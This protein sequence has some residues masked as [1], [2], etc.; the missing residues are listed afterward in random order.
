MPDL[1][2]WLFRLRAEFRLTPAWERWAGLLVA[3]VFALTLIAAH[4]PAGGCRYA[5]ALTA[6]REHWVC[7][8]AA[9]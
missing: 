1:W 6:G 5:L 9:P 8:E 4:S 3:A 7:A 2:L